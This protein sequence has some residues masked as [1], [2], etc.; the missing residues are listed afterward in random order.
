[1]IT[2]RKE[3]ISW[4]VVA[5]AFSPSIPEVE[6]GECLH[7][8]DGSGLQSKFRDSKGYNKETQFFKIQIN[9]QINK[10]K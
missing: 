4:A 5:L 9:K 7:F 1:M 10:S 8:E 6:T 2:R 3:P